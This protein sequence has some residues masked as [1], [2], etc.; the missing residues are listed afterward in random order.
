MSEDYY[1]ILGVSR[2][3]TEA[4][5]AKAYREL[6]R[7]YHPDM[8]PDDSKAKEKFQAVQRA[9]D[10]LRDPEKRKKYDRFG[11]DFES[12][13]GG[14]GGPDIDISQI[15]GG[16][17]FDFS[18]VMRQFT[19]GAGGGGPHQGR[20]QQARRRGQDLQME[21]EVPFQTAVLGGERQVSV[22]RGGKLE[23]ITVKIPAGIQDGTKMRLRNQG[24]Q[25][26]GG[27]GDLLLTIRVHEHPVFKRKGR[28]LHVI[29]PITIFEAA[30]GAKVDIPSP[31]GTVTLTVKSGAQSGDKLRMKGLGVHAKEGKGDLYAE[32]QIQ[33]PPS[34]NEADL[35]T[36]EEI[37]ARHASDPPPRGKLAW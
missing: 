13:Q 2:Q 35:Q 34:L 19:G 18:D 5:I 12:I 11:S 30:R 16:G 22:R 24:E 31:H 15:F 37:E 33:L 4:E 20:Q 10:I 17:G 36:L 32:L 3:A 6:A 29:V 26:A 25:A 7:K 9:Y 23:D 8:N 1:K 21:T 27:A 28:D 14:G